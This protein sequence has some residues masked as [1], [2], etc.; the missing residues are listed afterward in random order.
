[1]V[2]GVKAVKKQ[3]EVSD[4]QRAM[5]E[6]REEVGLT[7]AKVPYSHLWEGMFRFFSHGAQ[8]VQLRV[9]MIWKRW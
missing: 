5:N 7:Q 8:E 3:R 9:A 2:R 1:M 4:Y 6:F